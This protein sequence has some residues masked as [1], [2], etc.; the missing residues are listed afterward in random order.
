MS[1]E[2]KPRNAGAYK[3][4]DY[5]HLIER[6]EINRD[7]FEAWLKARVMRTVDYLT[8]G[9]AIGLFVCLG[10]IVVILRGMR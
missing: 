7:E 9:L 4:S 3:R 6:T 8:I 1:T 2:Y 10:L 5:A